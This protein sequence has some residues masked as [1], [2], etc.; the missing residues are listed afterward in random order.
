MTTVPIT[1]FIVAFWL[2]YDRRRERRY[3][4]EDEKLKTDIEEME[5]AIMAHL[6]NRALSKTRTWKSNIATAAVKV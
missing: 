3:K 5:K 4:E 6:R 1:A 2:W